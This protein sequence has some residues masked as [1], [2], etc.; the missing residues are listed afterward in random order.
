MI[1]LS[2]HTQYRRNSSIPHDS[3]PATY[4]KKCHRPLPVR[5]E[6]FVRIDNMCV[7]TVCEII[8]AFKMSPFFVALFALVGSTL[9]TRSAMQAEIAALR[10][11]FAVLQRS[12]PR[13]LHLKQSD[14]VL[15]MLLSRLSNTGRSKK[16]NSK[17]CARIFISPVTSTSC[18]SAGVPTMTRSSIASVA[19]HGKRIATLATNFQCPPIHFPKV[20]SDYSSPALS[21]SED[22]QSWSVSCVV[23][24]LYHDL[25]VLI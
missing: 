11:Q 22:L 10:H 19:E 9:Q 25:N 17:R 20:E 16:R 21:A 4:H 23:V 3:E 13:R 12:A 5:T 7:T 8:I 6:N 15:W 14:R 1:W 18:R 2:R 24:L